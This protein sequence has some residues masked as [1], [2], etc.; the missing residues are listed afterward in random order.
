MKKYNVLYRM[1]EAA[2]VKDIEIRATN[3]E[4]AWEKAFFES[5]PEAEGSPAYSAWVFSA[6]SKNGNVTFFNTFEGKPY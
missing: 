6:V 4:A 3:K 1:N 5:I 2:A